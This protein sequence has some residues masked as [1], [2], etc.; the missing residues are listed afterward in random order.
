[1]TYPLAGSWRFHRY[2]GLMAAIL[3]LP[4]AALA[5]GPI[6]ALIENFESGTG[7]ATA[8]TT[9]NSP[10]SVNSNSV[11]SYDVE[12][13]SGR[14][15]ISD[16]D[17][18]SNGAV[19]TLAG[20]IPAPGYYLFTA[21]VKVDSASAPIHSYGMGVKTGAAGTAKVSDVNAGYVMNL[22]GSGDAAL[23]YQTIGAAVNVPA[24]GSFP[25]DAVLYFS[26][27]VSGN[28]YNAPVADGD[29]SGRHRTNTATWAAGS[30]NAV[31]IDNI[32]RHGPGNMGEERHLWISVGD[33]Y[34]N[35]AALE[36]MLVQAKANNFTAVDILARYRA[37]AY[38]VPNRTDATYPN[39][40]PFGQRV[41]TIHA[42][43]E[44]DP[45][46]YTIDRCRELGL[47]VYISFSAFLVTPNSI[48]PETLPTG[49][50]MGVWP[51]AESQPRDMVS[52]D[53][54]NEGLWA[55]LGRKDVRDY[56]KNILMD[57]VSNYDIG[58]V[59]FDRI[60]YPGTRFGYNDQALADMGF[61]SDPSPFSAA[62][63]DARRNV[64]TDFLQECYEE[65][66]SKKPWIVVGATP[67]AFGTSMA[68]TYNNVFQHWPTWTSRKT[69]NREVSFG[70]LDIMQPQFYRLSASGAPESNNT[71]MKKALYGDVA[72]DSLD[73]GMMPGAYNMLAPL[74]YHPNS[75]DLA[76]SQINAQNFTD[77]RNLDLSG[78][79]LFAATRSLADM[80]LIRDP[81]A[82]TAG[83]DVLAGTPN[84][85][86]Y[87]FKAGYDNI[88]PNAVT[89]FNADPQPRGSVVFT[90]DDPAPAAD[91]ETASK[92][93]IYKS[94]TQPVRESWANQV[95]KLPVGGNWFHAPVGVAGNYYYRIVPVD[96]YNNRG[97]AME[98]GPI[99]VD[100]TVSTPD[101]LIID[102]T[103][104]TVV[105][106][107]STG[108]GAGRWGANYYFRSA[109]TGTNQIRFSVTVPATGNWTVSEWHVAG[110]NRAPDAPYIIQHSGGTST[111]RF[112]QRTNGG[113]WN[114][115]GDFNFVAGNTYTI[116]ITD[117]ATLAGSQVMADAI[118]LSFVPT[119]TVV[120]AQPTNLTA[121]VIS[122]SQINLS[123]N[124]NADN[125]SGYELERTICGG[126]TVIIPLPANTTSYS[127]S[128]LAADTEYKYVVRAWNT[129]AQSA[130]SNVVAARTLP[131]VPDDI[132]IDNTQAQLTGVWS[133]GAFGAFYG[134][135]Y[136]FVSK[137]T[138]LRTATFQFTPQRTA[139]YD[140][141]EW[142]VA[143]ANRALN[144]PHSVNHAGGS[145]QV[146][147]NQ[148]INGGKWNKIGSF[149]FEAGTN[150]SVVL[151]DTFTVGDV[152]MADAIR[153]AY[154]SEP[155]TTPAAPSNLQA[156][157][158]SD[159]EIG[160]TW[161]DNAVNE[162][163][164]EVIRTGP[165]G[166]PDTV[167][168][169]GADSI[170]YI[171][172][173][174]APLTQY[175]YVVR[176]VNGQGASANSNTATATTL[177]NLPP[178]QVIDNLNADLVGAWAFGTF[179]ADK[180]ETNY[181]FRGKSATGANHATFPVQAQKTG[182][183][184]FFEWHPVGGNRPTDAPHIVQHAG[185]ISTIL[186]NQQINGGQWN[187]LG[188]Y[189]LSEGGSYFVRITDKFTVGDVIMADGIKVGWVSEVPPAPDAPSGLTANGLGA[190]QIDLAW[191][192]NS[193]NED[194]FEI[195][196]NG[197]LLT[198]VGPNVTAYSDTAA[199]ECSPYSYSVKAVR[200]GVASDASNT[201]AVVLDATKPVI[202]A[203]AAIVI[204]TDP[205]S[206]SASGFDLGSPVI[207]D[208]CGGNPSVTSDGGSSFPVGDTV[209]TWTATDAH[210]NSATATQLV[211]VNDTEK[212]VITAPGD[213]T[214]VAT[215]ADC[216]GAEVELGL[217]VTW[218]N[219]GVVSV[220]NDAPTTY[221]VGSTTVTWAAADAYGNV[222]TATQAVIVENNPVEAPGE[223]EAVAQSWDK[224]L[225]TWEDVANETFYE[226]RYATNVDGPYT[227]AASAGADATEF[228]VDSLLP[229]T[230][231]YF[232]VAA[233]N[234]CS[235]SD[236]LVAVATTP[237]YSGTA[238]D[239]EVDDSWT[240]VE[241]EGAEGGS[242]VLRARRSSDDT[243][244][245]TLQ[246][247]VNGTYKITVFIPEVAK[248]STQAN[249]AIA[250]GSSSQSVSV[251]QR[252]YTGSW[253][254]L[255][256][257]QFVAGAAYVSVSQPNNSS[258]PVVVDG[259]KIEQLN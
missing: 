135:N 28:S 169:L 215:A 246:I 89:V 137:G 4:S 63:R 16:P 236:G 212:P 136:N 109:G 182:V 226:V 110:T 159:S 248:L 31:Y 167:A 195:I 26:T 102:N 77:A 98:I 219:T 203:P 177:S 38:Y 251:N 29:F 173:G 155:P 249:Y 47:K 87:L 141:Y 252:Q 126:T 151:S 206:S 180:W 194:G 71:L 108:T 223:A 129:G 214:V 243:A 2:F 64:I 202:T 116:T 161:H 24:G 78:F 67:I 130:D 244:V 118:K 51:A 188:S 229:N 168:A 62:F 93:F 115:L 189:V 6:T 213:V 132:I 76:Q 122:N 113:K 143:G 232:V 44:N 256:N 100:G 96:D 33:G 227:V 201:V 18:G 234:A 17:G 70:V 198:S 37:D 240:P 105:G 237:L 158:I 39:P 218:D 48:Y 128:S 90:W 156:S 117:N 187:S 140:V 123:W 8:V 3:A 106:A 114:P 245:W 120:P 131:Q 258:N 97:D 104:A 160:L 119:P 121:N 83:T 32:K 162:T 56:T 231:Y 61:A 45:L 145:S 69:A 94:T 197:S 82:S 52:A 152:M 199:S 157:T 148:Q 22:T 193:D 34:T 1:M 241:D 220:T 191:D 190:S 183:Y 101:D 15:K 111:V 247:P 254:E 149:L 40:E 239:P 179:S 41:G 81:G 99:S 85:V 134:S 139:V 68:D 75:G 235:E 253:V 30:S 124:D 175:S 184:E 86:D 55:D 255:G 73:F 186:V 147:V 49:S 36:N 164:Y 127:D 210:G 50:V 46:Q 58:G 172:T 185:G 14:L 25:Q 66:T 207:S 125:E 112:D 178:D 11:I 196:R 9:A 150:H 5:D 142:H 42:S 80:H 57:I 92:Y 20:A 163:G 60:R 91:G 250:N 216:F 23:G 21:D 165:G 133:T 13:A 144:A 72:V 209:V 7:G 238:N 221:P 208:N 59:I 107:W 74:F 204:N 205:G 54:S 259:L 19:L 154:N 43:P 174:L 88:K 171:D 53:N 181:A 166:T 138:G 27:D 200:F 65:V 192:D 257:F 170:S 84:K 222:A 176:A 12:S 95:T 242:Y 233:R 230:T 35:L 224:V 79:G 225:V 217:S 103:E 10:A 153:I 146:V 228:L 211:T